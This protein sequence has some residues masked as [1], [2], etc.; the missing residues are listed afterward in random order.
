M[1]SPYDERIEELLEEYRRQRQE[2]GELQQRLR[3]I[4]ATG[5]APRQTVKV[6]V[7]AQGELTGVEFP[8]GAYRRMAPAELTEA[9]LGAARSAREAALAQA[10]ELMASHLPAEIP[11][12]DFLQG[13]A[14]LTA[15]LPEQPSMPEAVR[16]Y[17]EQGRT[18]E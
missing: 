9:I 8:T 2:A 16:A 18:P 17:V 10:G 7:G 6:T 1:A 14:D 12:V 4:S 13:T 11:A 15:M 5:T 3:E